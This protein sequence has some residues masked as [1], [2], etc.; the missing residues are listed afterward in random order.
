MLRASVW[1]PN[2]VI[3]RLLQLAIKAFLVHDP[4]E[5]AKAELCA[6]AA[7]PAGLIESIPA[8]GQIRGQQSKGFANI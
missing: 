7:M 2:K 4:I 6:T 1:A 5:E 8:R 3:H